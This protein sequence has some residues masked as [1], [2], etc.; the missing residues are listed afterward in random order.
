MTE[1][2]KNVITFGCRLNNLESELIDQQIKEHSIDKNVVIFN[3]CAVTSEAERKA[4]QSIRKIKK[5][6]PNAKIVVTGCSAQIDP[7]KWLL[8]EEVSNVIGNSEK[9]KKEFWK[10]FSLNQFGH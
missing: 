9:T 1:L 7:S 6:N 5:E 8:M 10:N 3:T 2:L 4:R